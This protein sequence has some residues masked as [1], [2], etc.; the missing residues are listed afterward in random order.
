MSLSYRAGELY[1]Q[2]SDA[3]QIAFGGCTLGE[4]LSCIL[5]LSSAVLF[6]IIEVVALVMGLAL[7]RSITS[8]VHELFMGTERVRQGDFTHR[9]DVSTQR[10]ARRAGRVVQLR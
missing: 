3:Q 2:L 9:I 6:L 4:W 1:R 8:S 7:A 5:L 10:S